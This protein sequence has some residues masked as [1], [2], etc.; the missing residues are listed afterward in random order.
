M[1][2]N[3]LNSFGDII[4]AITHKM[5]ASL[6]DAVS[7]RFIAR[8]CHAHHAWASDIK[9]GMSCKTQLAAHQAYTFVEDRGLNPAAD[10]YITI[11]RILDAL[12]DEE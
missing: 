4:R 12:R 7:H 1:L 10:P 9:L 3:T 2:I 11:T 8:Q 5:S 6:Y